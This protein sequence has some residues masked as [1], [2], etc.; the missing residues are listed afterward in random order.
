MKL[1][2]EIRARLRE[3]RTFARN[4]V[5]RTIAP[6]MIKVGELVIATRS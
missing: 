3:R 5:V 6:V 1:R 4:A 2:E